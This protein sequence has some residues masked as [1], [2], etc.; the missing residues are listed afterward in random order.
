MCNPQFVNE[1]TDDYHLIA[2]QLQSTSLDTG[3]DDPV[4]VDPTTDL[5]GNPR[6]TDF[7]PMGSNGNF[8]GN[9]ADRACYE[10]P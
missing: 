10:R 7:P 6:L 1:A 2:D 4:G 5:D 8:F 3:L 9:I